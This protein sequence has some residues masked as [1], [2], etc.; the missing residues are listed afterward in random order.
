M[1]QKTKEQKITET[2]VE[3]LKSH[4]AG[5]RYTDIVRKVKEVL[6]EQ[7]ENMIKGTM[8]Q[9]DINNPKDI[10]KVRRGFYKHNLFKG[11]SENESI[12]QDVTQ[13]NA[14]REQ[15]FYESFADFLKVELEE[16]TEAIVLGGNRFGGRWGTPDVVG[17]YKS[18]DT[19]VVKRETEIVTAEIKIDTQSLI[20]AFGQA[21]AYLLFSHKVYIVIPRN[22]PE[23]DIRTYAFD[24]G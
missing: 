15:D 2:V 23:E 22:S 9:I 20:T 1:P 21:C 13:R 19:D 7:N 11:A 18:M 3:I 10:Y 4:P 16:C 6:P 17:K 24:I 8:F 12:P 5:L 14:L